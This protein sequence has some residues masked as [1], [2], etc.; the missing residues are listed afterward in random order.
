MLTI[1]IVDTEHNDQRPM[2][3]RITRAIQLI[4]QDFFHSPHLDTIAAH[5]GL[6]VFAFVRKFKH[7]TGVSPW[8]FILKGRI[9]AAKHRLLHSDLSISEIAYEVGWQNVSHFTALFRKHVGMTPGRYR[10]GHTE[11]QLLAA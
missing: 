8:Q 6:S 2:D 10:D 5:A 1:T 4:Q 3:R 9:E 7:E 11:H